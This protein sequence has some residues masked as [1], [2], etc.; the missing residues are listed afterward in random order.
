MGG[1]FG[2]LH[3]VGGA[4]GEHVDSEHDG[5]VDASVDLADRAEPGVDRGRVHRSDVRGGA[6][7]GMA[8]EGARRAGGGGIGLVVVR[9]AVVVADAGGL[10]SQ[11]R[12]AWNAAGRT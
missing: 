3:S 12:S 4:T 8:A 5:A 11:A 1:L 7:F 10:L 6:A 2:A 9:G